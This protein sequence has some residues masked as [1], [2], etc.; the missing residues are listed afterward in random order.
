[1][2]EVARDS[3]KVGRSRGDS[4]LEP[5]EGAWPPNSKMINFGPWKFATAALGNQSKGQG[6]C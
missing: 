5:S 3:Q 2:R 4:S 6:H 1:M